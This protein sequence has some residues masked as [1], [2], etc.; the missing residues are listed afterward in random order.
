M[1]Y[2]RANRLLFHHCLAVQTL[3]FISAS[4]WKALVHMLDPQDPGLWLSPETA[5]LNLDENATTAGSDALIRVREGHQLI[6]RSATRLLILY[7]PS[8]GKPRLRACASGFGEAGLE[9]TCHQKGRHQLQESCCVR[10]RKKCRRWGVHD[11]SQML[12]YWVFHGLMNVHRFK[13]EIK[14]GQ[15]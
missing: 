13:P 4:S 9:N 2:F 14:G 3:R 10:T 6:P 8:R 1:G 5:P 12:G 7:T 15:T 11:S